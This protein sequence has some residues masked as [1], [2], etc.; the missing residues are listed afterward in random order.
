MS[1]EN[2]SVQES[3][4]AEIISP[5]GWLAGW[6]IIEGGEDCGGRAGGASYYSILMGYRSRCILSRPIRLMIG[7]TQPGRQEP[8]NK[9]SG[10]LYALVFLLAEVVE[11]EVVVRRRALGRGLLFFEP[12]WL[13]R[14]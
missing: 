12:R 8:G 5:T 13:P 4:G 10:K 7:G 1:K 9:S 14:V 3:A 6:L 11:E 2:K